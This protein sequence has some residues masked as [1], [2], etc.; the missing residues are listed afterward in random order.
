MSPLNWS[1]FMLVALLALIIINERVAFKIPHLPSLNF[2]GNNDSVQPRKGEGVG[3]SRIKRSQD[4]SAAAKCPPGFSGLMAHPSDCSKFLN[5]DNGRTFIQN[6]GPGT[7]FSP[8]LKVCDFPYAVDCNT[9]ENKEK[10]KKGFE[11]E[12]EE[13]GGS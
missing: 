1:T 11:Q 9:E 10:L 13:G 7:L 12:K 6:C 4:Y 2:E 8:N 5:C 3:K